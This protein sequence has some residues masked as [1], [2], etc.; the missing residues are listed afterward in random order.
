MGA[1]TIMKR[2][3]CNTDTE[4]HTRLLSLKHDVAIREVSCPRTVHFSNSKRGQDIDFQC[5]FFPRVGLSTPL[6]ACQ[7]R[8]ARI[9]DW[10]S[11]YIFVFLFGLFRES[12]F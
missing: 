11:A 1:I 10:Y 8:I 9:E 4:R 7:D 12:L 3:L 6:S 2:S 5:F